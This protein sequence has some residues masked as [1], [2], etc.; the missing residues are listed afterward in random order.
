MKTTKPTGL[1]S[2]RGLVV[3]THPVTEAKTATGCGFHSD[4]GFWCWCWRVVGR[5]I[6][7]G[8]SV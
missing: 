4:G 5:R 8:R 6:S 2:A 3:P 1:V 7:S